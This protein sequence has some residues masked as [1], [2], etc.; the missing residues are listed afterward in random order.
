MLPFQ[1]KMQIAH[2]QQP[3]ARAAEAK[4]AR[5]VVKALDT[6]RAANPDL[7]TSPAMDQLRQYYVDKS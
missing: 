3:K 4:A 2:S 1:R 7:K 5:G 6:V